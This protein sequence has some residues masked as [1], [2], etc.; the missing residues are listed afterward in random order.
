MAKIL[1]KSGDSLADVYDIEGSIA[2][3]EDLQS[4]DVNLVH[5]MGGTIFSERLSAQMVLVASSGVLQS[6]TFTAGVTIPVTSRLLGLAVVVTLASRITQLSVGIGSPVAI[7]DT[8]IPI[9]VWENA[10]AAQD[11]EVLIDGTVESRE[12]LISPGGIFAPTILM[13]NDSPRRANIIQLRGETNAFGAGNIAV[14]VIAHILFP[15]RG[16]LSSR[17]LPIPGW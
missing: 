6:V 14:T 13:G 9:F 1:S 5:E 11:V 16:G 15:Q 2:G 4:K 7:D 3:I 17:G 8:E 12:L 10:D